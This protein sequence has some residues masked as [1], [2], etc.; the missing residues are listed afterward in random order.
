VISILVAM[1]LIMVGI[2]ELLPA[3]TAENQAT[4]V[5]FFKILL[6]YAL[7]GFILNF[8]RE[9]VKDIEDIDGDFNAGARTL[10][11]LMGRN[12]AGKVV[13]ALFFIP[14]LG[15]IYYIATYLYKQQIA[16][17]YF[18]VLIVAP[19]IYGC[20]QSYSAETKKDWQHISNLLKLVMVTGILSLLLYKYILLK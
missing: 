2:F 10:P 8:I 19:L 12:R 17:I 20:I 3:V 4:Q 14:I 16:L 11:I 9:I 7:F 13:F 1:S 6:D 5:T 18:L 15:L